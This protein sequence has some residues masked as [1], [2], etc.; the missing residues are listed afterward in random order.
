MPAKCNSVYTKALIYFC[1]LLA[2]FYL[3][4]LVPALGSEQIK[5]A[6][7][8]LNRLAICTIPITTGA[9]A[10]RLGDYTT[11]ASI[12]DSGTEAAASPRLVPSSDSLSAPSMSDADRT[13][14]ALARHARRRRELASSATLMRS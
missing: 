4:N 11:T 5:A 8:R 13:R 3:H 6:K 12:S 7:M 9:A 10:I 1:L 2:G 14:P